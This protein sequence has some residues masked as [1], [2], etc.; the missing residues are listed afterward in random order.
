MD[1]PSD[2]DLSDM[3]HIS[4]KIKSS[5]DMNLLLRLGTKRTKVERSGFERR[6]FERFC[7]PFTTKAGEWITITM[8]VSE[9]GISETL[10]KDYL[11]FLDIFN[12][13]EDSDGWFML[14]DLTFSNRPLPEDSPHTEHPAPQPSEPLV[15]PL[16]RQYADGIVFQKAVG[17][18]A[19]QR[20]KEAKLK[21]QV[22]NTTADTQSG[23]LELIGLPEGFTQKEVNQTIKYKVYSRYKTNKTVYFDISED[24]K[25]GE[26]TF[27]IQDSNAESMLKPCIYTITVTD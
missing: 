27:T 14:D 10:E 12:M 8:R 20:G 26:Y 21:I 15:S 6:D 23:T 25:P 24:V 1:I 2:W 7:H 9:F 16:P 17:G 4:F 3:T 22:H 11:R 19:F 18:N 5:K 13:D